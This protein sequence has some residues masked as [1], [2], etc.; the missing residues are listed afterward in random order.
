MF[1]RG[2]ATPGL[3]RYYSGFDAENCEIISATEMNI[4]M[5][6]P[7]PAALTNM[8]LIS[9]AVQ[10]KQGFEAA[11]GADVVATTAPSATGL[12]VVEEWLKGDHITLKRNENYWG[13]P[14]PYETVT[15]KYLTDASSRL[16]ALQSGDVDVIDRIAASEATLIENDANLKL[17]ELENV[18]NLYGVYLNCANA[19]LNDAKVRQAMSMAVNREALLQSVFF[20]RGQV[21]DGIFAKSFPMYSAPKADEAFA[22]DVEAAKAL[23]ADAGYADGFTITMITSQ[24]QAYIDIAQFCQAAWSPLGIKV[25]IQSSDS[26]TFFSNKNAGAYDAYVLAATGVNYV[27]IMKDYDNRLTYERSGATQFNPSNESEFHAAV[28]TL[29][30]SLDQGVA[31]DAAAVAQSYCRTEFPSISLVNSH[32]LFASKTSVAGITMTCMGE[33]NFSHVHPAQ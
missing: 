1:E 9:F 30:T 14:A 17:Y 33:S 24:T 26:A 18:Q 19:P 28:D 15:I 16:M 6:T 3:A 25:D 13:E 31:K 5:K 22:Y 10:S 20:G 4:A 23:L 8:T 29:Y 11:G 7:S 27:N 32:S 2:C 12:Y 21:A